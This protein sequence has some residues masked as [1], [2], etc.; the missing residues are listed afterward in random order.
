[1]E[2]VGPKVTRFRPGDEAYGRVDEQAG[3]GLLDLGAAAEYVRVSES[4][5]RLLPAG[6]RAD[7]A[8]GI[9]LAGRATER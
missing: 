4:S 5:I 9:P 2:T 3:T 7:E 1:M 6:V 8:A